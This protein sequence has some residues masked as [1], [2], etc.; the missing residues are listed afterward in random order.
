MDMYFNQVIFVQVEMT[1]G[2]IP[3]PFPLTPVSVVSRVHP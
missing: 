3:L 1:V 2:G